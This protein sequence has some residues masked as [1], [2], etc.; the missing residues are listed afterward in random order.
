MGEGTVSFSQMC[1]PYTKKYQTFEH[2]QN[3]IN[4]TLKEIEL[5]KQKK[6]KKNCQAL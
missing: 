5:K 2:F 6:T 4:P 3:K 1:Q